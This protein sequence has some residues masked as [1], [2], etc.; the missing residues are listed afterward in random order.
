MAIGHQPRNVVQVR[1]DLVAREAGDER[2]AL[3]RGDDGLR[4]GVRERVLEPLRMGDTGYH[5]APERRGRMAA[6][7]EIAGDGFERLPDD[8]ALANAYREW[9][10]APGGYGLVSTLDD[11][12][13][14][15]RM[16]VEGGSLDGTR[17][18]A[19]DTVALMATDALSANV[20][21]RSWLPGKGQVGFGIDFA[22]RRAAGVM[23]ASTLGKIE[24]AG[25]DVL[26]LSGPG[27]CG[28][29]DHLH[30]YV[31]RRCIDQLGSRRR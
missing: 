6:M 27:L 13:R 5:V 14:F 20:T 8:A 12:M 18:L 16:L 15:G 7:Y 3:I 31:D 2:R 28:R 4:P 29:S 11:Y 1:R 30:Q 10:M 22:V 26:D 9:P 23:D 19:A 25:T 17:V 21:D 24:L